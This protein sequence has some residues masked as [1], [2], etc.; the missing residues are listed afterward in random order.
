[1]L[2]RK[3]LAIVALVLVLVVAISSV[4]VVGCKPK[5]ALQTITKKG[6][7]VVG[8]SADY[9]PYEYVDEKTGEYTGF[10][11][12]LMNEIAKRMNV[13]VEWQDMDFDLLIGAVQNGQIDAVIAC[14][15]KNEERMTQVLFTDE[16]VISKDAVLIAAT[17]TLNLTDPAVDFPSL[18]IGTQAGTIQYTWVKE[19]LV[20]QGKMPEANLS[21][22]PRADQAVQDLEAGRVDAVFLDESVADQFATSGAVKKALVV[23]L[24]GNPAIACKLGEDELVAKINEIIKALRDEGFTK[25][26]CDKYQIPGY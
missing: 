14:M 6:T 25:Q 9:A 24:E 17:S 11:I 2:S 5:N 8:T 1:M 22:Y 16:Y 20:D 18:K 12:D 21:Q 10:D 4:F 15:T 23:D 19:N 7:I 13:T 3:H 26:L